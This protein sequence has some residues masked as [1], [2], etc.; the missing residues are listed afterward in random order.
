MM[1]AQRRPLTQHP[2]IELLH[3]PDCPNVDAAW[4]LLRACLSEL[5]LTSL[6]VADKTGEFPSPSIL[7]NGIDVTGQPTIESASCRLDLPTRERVMRAL[8]RSWTCERAPHILNTA[9]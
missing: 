6:E 8:A 2:E 4:S 9:S 1:A 3:L 5:G 7:V